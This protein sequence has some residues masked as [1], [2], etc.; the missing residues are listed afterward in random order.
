MVSIQ[1][2]CLNS[3]KFALRIAY[4]G[5]PFCGWQKQPG[6]QGL[7]PHPQ[8]SIQDLLE[9][10]IYQMTQEKVSVVGSGRTDRGV[11]AVA[12][13][14]HFKLQA[15]KFS[16]EIIKRGLNSILPIEIRIIDAYVVPAEFHAQRSAVKKQYSYYFQQGPCP[17]PQMLE[18]SWWIYKRL[19]VSAMN[20]AINY[21]LGEHDFK[22]FQS[23]GGNPGRSTVRTILEAEVVRLPMSEIP[24]QNLNEMGFNLVRVRLVGTGFLKQMVRGIAGTLLQIGEQARSPDSMKDL[25]QGGIR[26][27]VGATAPAKGLTLER[28]WYTPEVYEYPNQT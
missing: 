10:A 6:P 16:P 14:A 11:H 27:S 19:D 3:R 24:G 18:Q 4:L 26:A 5:T 21:L 20:Q 23:R 28:V 7:S 2:S 25:L 8:P 22:V 9:S 15:K 1:D 12:Q 13:V 17:L